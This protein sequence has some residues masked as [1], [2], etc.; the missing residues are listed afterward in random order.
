M[1][2]TLFHSLCARLKINDFKK[3]AAL[4]GAGSVVVKDVPDHAVVAGSP[5][6]VIN[7][8]DRLPYNVAPLSKMIE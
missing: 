7:T 1:A 6:K 2:Y 3:S 8:T 4:V 5:A